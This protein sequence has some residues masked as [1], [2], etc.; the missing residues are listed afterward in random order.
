MSM[1]IQTQSAFK[2]EADGAHRLSVI[3]RPNVSLS[4]RGF[5][6]LMGLFGVVSFSLGVFFWSLGAWPVLG[7]FGLDVLLLYGF[8][9]LNY[10]HAAR[11]EKIE[12]VDGDLV[13]SQVNPLGAA[14]AWTFSPHWVRIKLDGQ[15]RDE[16]EVGSLVLSS[17]GQY[18]ALGAFLSPR[19]RASLA[20][21]LETSLAEY[22]RLKLH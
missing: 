16:D 22:R 19:E 20:A 10:H 13:F 9:K 21:Y 17:H 1:S 12:L 2:V 4:G 8:F 3:I 5:A 14:R 18:V 15:G 6:W 11:Y 7:F